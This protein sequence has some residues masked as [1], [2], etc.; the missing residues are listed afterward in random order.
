MERTPHRWLAA[1]GLLIALMALAAHADN[2]PKGLMLNLDLRKIEDGLIPNKTLYPLYVP[3]GDLSTE[4]DN[5]RTF[6]VFKKEQSLNI[7]HSSLLDPGT[8][9]W[10]ATIRV[11][12][13]TDG[14][15]MSQGNDESGY[16]IYIKDG[17]VHAA[18]RTGQSTIL[19]QELPENG[20][21]H[22]LNTWVT[23]EVNIQ[24]EMA[25]L[26]LNRARVAL[27]RI[28]EPPSGQNHYI[29]IGEHQ[30]LPIALQHDAEATPSGFTGAI[31]SFKILRQ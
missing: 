28:S 17:A 21:T 1:T 13:R 20:I 27:A 29:Q 18:I 12:A 19:L 8:G 23:I 7:P 2:L 16:V 14:I 5:R 9:E 11:F 24:P 15:V 22:C 26:S 25:I 3:M 4:S 31:S 6:L 10:I 30:T